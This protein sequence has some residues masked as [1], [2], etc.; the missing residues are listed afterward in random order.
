VEAFDLLYEMYRAEY[1]PPEE[2]VESI[3]KH[4]LFGLDI[5]KRAAQ[6]AQFAVL[7]KAA[8]RWREVLNTGLRPQIYAM[9]EPRPFSR[10]EVLDFLG[11]EGAAYA[12]A[13]S[14]ALELMQQAQNLGS[15]MQF[16]LPAEA[17]DYIARRWAHFQAAP[18][19]SFHEQA[20]L[21]AL[22]AYLPVLL[23]LCQKYEA[24]VAN[25]PYMG[26]GNMNGALKAYVNVRYPLSKSDLFAVFME[27]CL[28]LNVRDGL[29]GMINQHSWM[30]LSS[31]EKLREYFLAHYRI[32]SMLHLGPRTF[33][34]LSGEVVQSTA[35]VLA[36]PHDRT[37][38]AA[39]TYYRL[40]DYKDVGEKEVRFL[41][42]IDEYGNIPQANYFKI[43]GSPIAYWMSTKSIDLYHSL[44]KLNDVFQPRAGLSTCD[45]QRFLRNWHEV[46]SSSVGWKHHSK[47]SA[48]ESFKKWFPTTKGGFV[49]KWYGNNEFVVN[50]ENDGAEIKNFIVNNPN[51]PSTKSWS[52]YVRNYKYY[53]NPGITFGDVNSGKASFRFQEEGSI[54][55]AR[56]PMI[57]TSSKVIMGLLNSVVAEAYLKVL[58]PTLT[59]NVGDVSKIPV[60]EK[61]IENREVEAMVLASINIS[62]TDW[63][64]RETS[65]DF[66]AS[67][68]LNGQPSLRQAYAAWAERA[69]EDFFQL[70]ANEEELNRIFIGIYGLEEELS[71]AVALKDVTILQEELE[72]GQGLGVRDEGLGGR[73]EGVGMRDKGLGM[74]DEGL[75]MRDEGVEGYQRFLEEKKR[76][77]GARITDFVRLPIKRKVVMQQFLSYLIGLCM[78]RYRLD[79]PGLHIAHPNPSPEEL[80]P[81]VVISGK[82]LGSREQMAIINYLCDEHKEFSRSFG[83]A[84]INGPGDQ[85]IPADRGLPPSGAVRVDE[86]DQAGS[87]IDT[88]EHRRGAQP[89]HQG[90]FTFSED[91]QGLPGRTGNPTGDSK[92]AGLPPRARFSTPPGADD[93]NIQNAEWLEKQAQS[94][95]PHPSSLIPHPSPLTPHPSSLTPKGRRIKTPNKKPLALPAKK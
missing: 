60:H 92:E 40:V 78:G 86:S 9:P 71:P 62:R 66:Q 26:S 85:D 57:F 10:Q 95:I 31:Y 46:S 12:D 13:L 35:F 27:V 72:W 87:G 69:A 79:R 77:E 20:L 49:R 73:D 52:R 17:V 54:P 30:F 34:E 74:R 11:R 59:F 29:M 93:R 7:L 47:K 53:F 58:A 2:A 44:Q 90:V 16:E 65:W 67:P 89:G 70:H 61:C 32:V 68:L 48:K 6:L 84:K 22:N 36:N 21:P 94:L 39:G 81:Y 82:G 55:N 42:R 75:G 25:P 41:K 8:A 45:N 3:L 15:I 38:E 28:R 56:G 83:L 88:V 43:P 51:D 18:S 80:A 24:V 33:E 14:A 50:W 37:P 76:E 19:L 91:R 23:L 5:D 4:N 63:D 64:S 1:Y